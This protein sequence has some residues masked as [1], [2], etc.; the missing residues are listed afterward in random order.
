[1]ATWHFVHGYFEGVPEDHRLV[2]QKIKDIARFI[3][4]KNQMKD[5]LDVMYEQLVIDLVQLAEEVCNRG[6]PYISN[7]SYGSRRFSGL[8]GT[9]RLQIGYGAGL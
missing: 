3:N 5:F 7:G 4:T 9:S 8:P 2:Y 1:M 6:F